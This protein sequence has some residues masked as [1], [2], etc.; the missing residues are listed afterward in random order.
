MKALIVINFKNYKKSAGKQAL[1]IA[2][3]IA[4]AKRNGYDVAVCPSFLTTKEIREKTNLKVFSQHL[5][6]PSFGKHTGHVTLEEL[7]DIG[8]GGTLLNH[9]EK[10]LPFNQLKEI[11]NFCNKKRFTTIVCASTL[12]EIKKVATLK[13]SYI[14]YEPTELIGGD[15][16][17]TQADPDVILKAVEAVKQITKK[18]KVLC[19]AGIHQKEDLG[20][21]MLLGCSGILLAHAVVSARDPKKFLEEMLL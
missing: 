1:T 19:G 10:K 7:K 13:P 2:K 3:N 14:A 16:S 11:V 6:L 15:I 9:S 12:A 20:Q 17:V 18:T 8:V 4:K 21:A 5:D